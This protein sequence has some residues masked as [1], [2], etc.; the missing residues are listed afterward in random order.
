MT[1]SEENEIRDYLMY[2]KLPIDILL[3]VN[4]HFIAQISDLQQTKNIDFNAA[5][6][7]TKISWKE[8]L[9]PYVP[10]FILNKSHA[11]MRTKFEQKIRRKANMNLFRI[12]IAITIIFFLSIYFLAEF[13]AIE[14]ILKFVKPI[15]VILYFIPVFLIIYNMI[16]NRFAFKKVHNNYKFSIYQWRVFLV[17]N[18]GNL[19][20][21]FMAPIRSLISDFQ[22]QNFT[23]NFTINV[24]FFIIF[25]FMCIY[26]SAS[27]IKLA[28]TLKKIKPQLQF[29]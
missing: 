29:T 16:V 4:D 17:F 13:G 22:N 18:L 20:L 21:Q 25:A 28:L 2:K 26:T 24:I 19:G 14:Q 15:L 11:V 6:E 3:E 7:L 9:S 1:K 27:Q 5:F 12:S 23:L 8:E 10:W